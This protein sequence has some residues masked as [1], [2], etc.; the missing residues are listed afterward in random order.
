M[1]PVAATQLGGEGTA[2]QP[3][4]SPPALPSRCLEE[5]G[6]CLSAPVL[7]HTKAPVNTVLSCVVAGSRD[8]HRCPAAQLSPGGHTDRAILASFLVSCDTQVTRGACLTGQ[9]LSCTVWSLLSFFPLS[10]GPVRCFQLQI[11]WKS[12]IFSV[13]M[14]RILNLLS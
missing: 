3:Q 1:G 4:R 7:P 13:G 10:G 11:M 8:P 6:E 2:T 9:S 5:L 14:N 12:Y